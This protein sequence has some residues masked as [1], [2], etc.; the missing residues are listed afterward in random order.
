MVKKP[1][2]EMRIRELMNPVLGENLLQ[3]KR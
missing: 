2:Q 3:E 1:K